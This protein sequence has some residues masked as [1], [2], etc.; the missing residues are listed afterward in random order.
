MLFV[1]VCRRIFND[2]LIYAYAGLWITG[3]F[4]NR[5]L[6]LGLLLVSSTPLYA[7]VAQKEVKHRSLI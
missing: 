5:L 3:D 1:L 6:F 2:G 7:Q 4:M